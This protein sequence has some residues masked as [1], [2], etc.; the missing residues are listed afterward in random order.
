MP[1]LLLVENPS[2]FVFATR[3][4]YRSTECLTTKMIVARCLLLLDRFLY[5]IDH[6]QIGFTN[7]QFPASI[8]FHHLN[9]FAVTL[10]TL[11]NNPSNPLLLLD[12]ANLEAF[13]VTH[14]QITRDLAAVATQSPSEEAAIWAF[15]LKQAI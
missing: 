3:C 9:N 5:S 13:S 4:Y 10:T 11:R 6:R 12:S 14:L 1:Y 7:L 2:G 8:G 15:G